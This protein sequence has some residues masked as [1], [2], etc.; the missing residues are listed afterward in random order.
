MNIC[1]NIKLIVYNKFFKCTHT[2][3]HTHTHTSI[4]TIALTKLLIIYYKITLNINNNINYNILTIIYKY[5]ILTIILTTNILLLSHRLYSSFLQRSTPGAYYPRW[6][7]RP[8]GLGH[9][10]TQEWSFHWTVDWTRPI[11][12]GLFTI[13]T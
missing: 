5:N 6:P 10:W 9:G 4:L 8:L 12:K 11:E 3:T 1:Q 2:I 7:W 13:I